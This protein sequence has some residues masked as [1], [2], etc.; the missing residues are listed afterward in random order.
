[1]SRDQ[2]QSSGADSENYQA[3]RDIV[4]S[5]MSAEEVR[6]I[7]LDVY[8]ANFLELR[9]VAE[10]I[11]LARAEKVTVAFLERIFAESPESAKNLNDP[12]VQ[13]AVFTAQSEFAKSGDED[14]GKLLIDLLTDR[15]K[16]SDRNLRALVLNEALAAAPKLTEGQRRA[17]ALIFLIRYT[18]TPLILGDAGSVA[19]MRFQSNILRL[20]NPTEPLRQVDFQHIEYVG[21]GTTSISSIGLGAAL[22][23]SQSSAFTHG[24]AEEQIPTELRESPLRPQL[25]MPA[26][27]DP[28]KWQVKV[29]STDDLDQLLKSLNAEHLRPV[30]TQVH[31]IGQIGPDQVKAEVVAA[32]PAAEA[33]FDEWDNSL[34]QNMNLTSVGIAIGHAY[35]T[36]F[37]GNSDLSIWL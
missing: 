12:D 19:V 33:I 9:G 22:L 18:R 17:V 25:L 21:A 27:R 37:G 32:L 8:S 20:P 10:E 4:I 30:L 24:F 28:E 23:A 7:A 13:A 16:Q 2:E 14:L 15:V 31:G 35:W 3:G 26:L 36:R 11:A 34:L 29:G 1:M 5:G 6:Q